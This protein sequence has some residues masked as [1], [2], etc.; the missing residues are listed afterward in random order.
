MEIEARK[1]IYIPLNFLRAG[2]YYPTGCVGARIT[3]SRWWSNT[4][5]SAAD[6]HY[7]TVYPTGV[8]PQNYYYRGNGFA[9]RCVVR[10]G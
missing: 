9:V 1:T 5:G 4:V 7:L 2:G 8:N 6:S 10:E 3:D